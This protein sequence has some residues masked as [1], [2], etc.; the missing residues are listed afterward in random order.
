[1]AD[2]G[3]LRE[4]ETIARYR[5]LRTLDDGGRFA[6]YLAEVTN[7]RR[8]VAV[9]VPREWADREAALVCF[10]R[11]RELAE[12]LS[13]PAIVA[14]LSVEEDP[15]FGPVLVEEFVD[16]LPLSEVI[17]RGSLE[18][19]ERL[20][21][22]VEAV[23]AL[24]IA[25]AEDVVHG[26]LRPTKIF[27]ERG[28]ET[29]LTGFGASAAEATPAIAVGVDWAYRAPELFAGAPHSSQTDEY[30]L[31]VVAFELLS[32]R[33]P[34]GDD[35]LSKEALH[36]L[37][38][39]VR[40]VFSKALAREPSERYAS[41]A[42]FVRELIERLALEERERTLL[43]AALPASA[44]RRDGA[45]LPMRRPFAMALAGAAAAFLLH[46]VGPSVW[47]SEP[48]AVQAPKVLQIASEPAG[49][50]VLVD[51]VPLGRTP[52]RVWI[53]GDAERVHVA[54][55]DHRP[56][57]LLL[58]DGQK[59]ITVA[60]EPSDTRPIMVARRSSRARG[61]QDRAALSPRRPT[62]EPRADEEEPKGLIPFVTNWF[63]GSSR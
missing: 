13:H 39:E 43:L 41:A 33:L 6:V 45:I 22:L 27:V 28:G 54:L 34:Y 26:N 8:R 62:S 57:D 40:D 37:V 49:A 23:A 53:P 63:N 59:V 14:V 48:P 44:R 15:H 56:V 5:V 42:V 55:E 24:E 36:A 17:R 4:P 25:H 60:L 11:A 16:G 20:H 58:S 30:A 21:L 31:A 61:S 18:N 7:S 35:G 19:A 46:V 9:R 2:A 1:M 50:T 10:V 47:R 51:G 32:G 52:R 3:L 38:P 12:R 29:R